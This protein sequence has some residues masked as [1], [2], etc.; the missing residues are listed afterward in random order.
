MFLTTV[1]QRWLSIR[2]DFCGGCLVF[3]VA[4]MAAT[5]GGGI[6]PA[7]IALCLTYMVGIVQ[8]LGMVTR[9]SAEVENNM[10]AVERILAYSTSL[11]QEKHADVAPPAEWPR[12]HIQFDK[13]ALSYRPGLPLVLKGISL[14]IQ[15]GERIGIVGRTGAGKSSIT[16][17]LFRLCELASGSISIDGIDVSTLNLQALRSNISIIPQDPVLFSGTLR[18]NLD[19]FD[20]HTDAELHDAIRRSHLPSRCTLDMVIADEGSNLSIGE[21]SLVSLARALVRNVSVRSGFN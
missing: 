15:A 17:A 12:G 20:R 8:I 11:P 9:Q 21:R 2:L 16:I 4:I 3:A 5:G 1:N 18:S 14:D 7:E 13:V 10:N 19:P 6:R